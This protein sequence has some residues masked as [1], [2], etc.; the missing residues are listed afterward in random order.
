MKLLFLPLLF[1]FLSLPLQTRAQSQEPAMLERP[2]WELGIGGGFL[3]VP[4][5]PGSSERELRGIAL[6]YIVYRGD[7]LRVGDGQ[8]ARAVALESQRF[9]LSM[10]F[11]AAFNSNSD[12]NELRVGM[13]DLD[14]LFEAGPQ[15]IY[16]AGSFSFADGSRSELQLTLQA[17]AVLSTDFKGIGH[18]G[19][20]LEPMLR[21]RHYG[22]LRP[23]LQATVSLRPAWAD[24]SL[25]GYFYDVAPAYV[26]AERPEYRAEKGYFGTGLNFYGT[27]HFSRQGRLFLGLQTSFLQ[28]ARNRASPLHEKDFN[29]TVGAGFIWA[30]RESRRT[31]LRPE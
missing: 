20:V 1:V 19:Y 2:L 27:W 30:L 8:S 25:H 21:Y 7:V 11:D 13:P 28:G 24:R 18:E 31:V 12:D 15:L 3:S 14:Y 17:R 6:P 29:V 9:E 22:F 10:S 4:D 26:T 5:Y 16:R 23:D